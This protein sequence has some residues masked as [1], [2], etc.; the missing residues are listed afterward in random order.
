MAHDVFISYSSHDKTLADGLCAFLE[1]AGIR[2]WIAPR[3]IEPG[4]DWG[5][6]LIQAIKSSRVLVLVFSK[7]ANTSPQILRE[8]ESAIHAGIPLVPLRIEDVLPEGGLE[9]HLGTVHWLDAMTP[10]MEAHLHRLTNALLAL[11]NQEKQHPG[12]T[13]DELETAVLAENARKAAHAHEPLAPPAGARGMFIHTRRRIVLLAVLFLMIGGGVALWFATPKHGLQKILTKHG[14]SDD[15]HCLAFSPDGRFL[16]SGGWYEQ[17]LGSSYGAIEIWDVATGKPVHEFSEIRDTIYS[18]AYSPDGRYLAAGEDSFGNIDIWDMST[19]RKFRSIPKANTIDTSMAVS[20]SSDGR[21]LAAGASDIRLWDFA[22]GKLLNE[23]SGSGYIL[24]L[25]FSPGGTYLA[26]GT[27]SQTVELWDVE[28]G[29]ALPTLTGLSGY[30]DSVA[31]SPD[32]HHLA[33][34]G[35]DLSVAV[36][37]LWDLMSAKDVRALSGHRGVVKT[38]T[39]SPDGHSLASAGLDGMIRIS[40]AD[41]VKQARSFVRKTVL[42]ESV[43]ALAFSPDGHYLA[44]GD[45]DFVSLWTP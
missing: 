24:S 17:S 13:A 22:T 37:Q 25:A 38:V 3:D 36:L 20:L 7:A 32:S 21:Y 16:A 23:F 35:G 15:V 45:G 28:T 27:T 41:T 12:E 34:G 44:V 33:A 43:N 18:L 14:D 42:T 26:A 31:F 6:A 8:V 4:V 39:F 30:V 10:P 9:F 40:V 2:C 5:S 19:Y 11:L 29:K 1:Q